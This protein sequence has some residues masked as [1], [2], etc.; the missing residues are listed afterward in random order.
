MATHARPAPYPPAEEACRS[1]MAR[2]H[3]FREAK[4]LL[5]VS[6]N[7]KKAFLLS[8]CGQDVLNTATGLSAATG[9]QAVSWTELQD[10]LRAHYAPP[11]PAL[12]MD[13]KGSEAVKD[14]VATLREIAG[15]F[16]FRD[17][18]EEM[19]RDG[20][21]LGLKDLSLRR[22][23]MAKFELTFQAAL[24]EARV[25]KSSNRSAAAIQTS[26]SSHPSRRVATLHHECREHGDNTNEDNKIHH[27][28]SEGKAGSLGTG[29]APR[30]HQMWCNHPRAACR[31]KD[32]TCQ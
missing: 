1:Y 27:A 17:L 11:A 14:F 24:D 23:L 20:L 18:E 5:A 12:V 7:R 2:F 16:K 28:R 19:M 13:Q 15:D 10:M 31:S 30:W 21:V 29:E 9:L 6:D 3:I 25:S 4:D 8:S 26:N 32:T 22:R